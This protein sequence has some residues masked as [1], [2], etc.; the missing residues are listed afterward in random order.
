M[1]QA[2]TARIETVKRRRKQ[3]VKDQAKAKEARQLQRQ[4][5]RE[6]S[7]RKKERTRREKKSAKEKKRK[8]RIEE[9]FWERA[10]VHLAVATL[11]VAVIALAVAAFTLLAMRAVA[12]SADN[13]A[14]D[15]S[16]TQ[17]TVRCAVVTPPCTREGPVR[18]EVSAGLERAAVLDIEICIEVST[19]QIEALYL[20]TRHA[21]E[22]RFNRLNS[23]RTLSSGLSERFSPNHSVTIDMMKPSELDESWTFAND[24]QRIGMVYVLG[25]GVDGRKEVTAIPVEGGG[26]LDLEGLAELI[27]PRQEFSA[28]PFNRY[29][30]A[31][32]D[33]YPFP[34][35]CPQEAFES[36]NRRFE[37]LED[38]AEA[39]NRAQRE[40]FIIEQIEADVTYIR[41][42]FKKFDLNRDQWMMPSSTYQCDNDV[43]SPEANVSGDD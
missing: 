33:R 5:K 36:Y 9:K 41:T 16:S 23:R 39:F 42:R 15:S 35:D 26:V 2:I 11:F 29:M 37:F 32:F 20:I 43:D 25:I 10:N 1:K 22:Y 6:E 21:G 28:E 30:L 17:F 12:D 31:T 13:I 34:Y 14:L 8:Q 4:E 7:Q 24:G 27:S 38:A 19:G 40:N 18:I 3:K